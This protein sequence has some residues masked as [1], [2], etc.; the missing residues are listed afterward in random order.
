MARPYSDDLRQSALRLVGAGRSCRET[1]GL[2]GIT[3]SSV[4][5]WCERHRKTGSAAAGQMGGHRALVLLPARECV[6]ARLAAAPDLTLRGLVAELTEQGIS[7]SYGL[8]W[9]LLAAD[10]L[11][12]K[13]TYTPP[14]RRDLTSPVG[15]SAGSGIRLGSTQAGGVSSTRPG[16]RPT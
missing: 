16:P 9:R 7:A 11:T 10:G 8:V 13:K 4:I 6:L 5:R 2:L 3:A 1:A 12:F 15:A 14:R